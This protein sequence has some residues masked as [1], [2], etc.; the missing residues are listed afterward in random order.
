MSAD[1][2]YVVVGEISGLFGVRGWVKVYSYTQ[3]R[4]NILHYQQWY[5]RQ[6]DEWSPCR[7]EDGREHGHGVVAKLVGCDDRD[8]AI[9]LLKCTI[10][11]HR[12]QLQPLPDDEYYWSDL[13]GLQVSTV[14]GVALGLVVALFETGAND[15][16]SVKDGDTE[17]LI[18]FIPK[19]VIHDIDLEQG[20]MQVDWDPEF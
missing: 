13:I 10:A 6:G 1:D 19:D 4:G 7:L 9:P 18:P 12:D 2:P 14:D 20:T 5:L 15:V 11:I 17:R 3:P 8:Q 16:L